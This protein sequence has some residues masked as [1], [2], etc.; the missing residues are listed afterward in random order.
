MKRLILL[1]FI[2]FA[3]IVQ[4][5]SNPFLPLNIPG[6]THDGYLSKSRTPDCFVL[7]E[8]GQ[9]AP[10]LIAAN[11]HP[12]LVRI[13]GY[14]LN[15]LFN[16][17]G[18]KPQLLTDSARGAENVIIVGTIGHSS[19]IDE[20]TTAGKIQIADIKGKREIYLKQ[21]VNNPLP[22][23]DRAF[24]IAGTDK[25]GTFYGLLDLSRNLGVSPWYWWADVP[26][27][28]KDYIYIKPGRFIT[29][30]P[31]VRLRGFFINNEAPAL[32]RWSR[33]TFGGFN[34][35]FYERVFELLLRLKGNFLWPAMW[36]NAFY[37]DCPHNGA[38][39]HEMGIVISTSHHEPMGRAHVEWARYGHGPWNYQ[40][41]QR[42]LRDFWRTGFER[43]KNFETL[44]TL[45]MRGDGD[46]PMADNVMIELLERIVRDQ[47][48]II[49]DITGRPAT[50][51]PQVWA[52]YKEVQYYYEKGMR[53]PDDVMI[54]YANDNW[55]N[56]RMLP[57]PNAPRR[58]GGYGMYY[59]F[60]YVGGPRN[61]KWLN[62][63]QVQ[64]I[65]EQMNLTWEHGVDRL[66]LVNVGDIKP[67]EYPITFFL[68]MAWNPEQ[69]NANNLICHIESFTNEQFGGH[70][71][72]ESAMLINM[73]SKFNSRVTPELLYAD[74]YSFENYDEWNR[75][76]TDY[77]NLLLEAFKIYY[78]MP[79]RY[80]D[81]FD[82]LVLFPIQGM[83]NLY[84]M[85]YAVARNRSLAQKNDPGANYW[86]DKAEHHFERDSLLTIKY[87]EVIADGKWQHMMDQIRIGY[88]Y[89][90]QPRQ[91]V[92]PKVVRV[93]PLVPSN[94]ELVFIE[95]DGFV[96][97]EAPHFNR[98]NN[99]GNIFW[100]VIPYMGRTLS[101]VTTLPA[102][103]YPSPQDQVYLEYDIYFEKTGD[104]EVSVMLSPTLNFNR[105]RG[106]RYAVSFN[107]GPE[108]VVNFNQSFDMNL[109][110]LW[111]ANNINKTTTR[112]T[113]SQPGLN[114]LRFRVLEP[115]VV[116]QKILIDTGG[117]KPSYLG[118]P[119]SKRMKQSQLLAN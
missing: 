90:Q 73:Y 54:L 3:G 91:R 29:E 53:V 26:V 23:I 114:T 79:E 106:L 57:D 52:L 47:R 17:T 67:M 5:S 46:E 68:D 14:F 112:H 25:R 30:E 107:G 85:Y 108:K 66:W 62:V 75:V 70:F 36:G 83:S 1:S 28:E 104:F 109:M 116:L 44:T 69:F 64:R 43:K 58:S 56:V 71:A 27:P 8:N 39:A 111:Q 40:K 113:I 82:Q 65:W 97:I 21:V 98:K 16:I 32:S 72:R 13:A 61:Y 35:K 33:A 102:N 49:A 101:S 89:W 31:R 9:V 50:E 117:L 4:L 63:R 42:V 74:T 99:S 80:R 118:P 24:V 55:G 2:F 45:G 84:E 20:L 7:A 87:N 6:Q 76:N 93:N 78:L 119:E 51:T 103:E 100:Q 59:H 88:T 34:H 19:L 41:N 22:G 94:S 110:E 18:E 105:S 95:T 38:L 15:D 77:R 92:M 48:R 115:G 37:D 96:S 12:G 60:D 11:D 86:A 81:A 10:V